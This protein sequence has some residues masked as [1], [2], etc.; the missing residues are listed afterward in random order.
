MTALP[1]TPVADEI[2]IPVPM[3][4]QVLAQVRF[5]HELRE[6][7]TVLDGALA[8]A[9]QLVEEQFA[10]DNEKLVEMVRTQRGSLADEETKLR[11]M[12]ITRFHTTDEKNPAPG[13]GIR[14]VREVEYDP[15]IALEW[16][17]VQGLAL[18]LD[19]KA[20]EKIALSTKLPCATIA[21]VPQ[22][23]LAKDL[24]AAL[25]KVDP[26][27]APATLTLEGQ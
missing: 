26:P 15:T 1:A 24:G 6:G 5:V 14:L 4:D 16:A 11:A 18:Q 23:T 10:R 17:R 20:F 3:P 9:R 19:R 27:K 8:E 25:A 21:I 13:V 12:A 2:V 7:L 22:A